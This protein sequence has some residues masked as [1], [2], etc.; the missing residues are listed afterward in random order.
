MTASISTRLIVP[1]EN[2]LLLS[3]SPPSGQRHRAFIDGGQPP[4]IS[5]TLYFVTAETNFLGIAGRVASK[6]ATDG[7]SQFAGQR[8]SAELI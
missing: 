3:S 5:S 2:I 8:R 4:A 7:F 6:D 1:I